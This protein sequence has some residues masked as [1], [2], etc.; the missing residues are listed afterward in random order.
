MAATVTSLTSPE[1]KA[2]LDQLAQLKQGGKLCFKGNEVS[3][4]S[5]SALLRTG[6]SWIGYAC[7]TGWSRD[8]NDLTSIVQRVSEF[9]NQ[10]LDGDQIL[11]MA[12]KVQS[13]ISGLDVLKIEYSLQADKAKVVENAIT[14]LSIVSSQMMRSIILI[15]QQMERLKMENEELKIQKEVTQSFLQQTEVPIRDL[16]LEDGFSEETEEK[17]TSD[18]EQELFDQISSI[19]EQVKQLRKDDEVLLAKWKENLSSTS[20]TSI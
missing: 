5:A 15:A 17:D 2:I 11:I 19:R 8:I 9:F 4:E 18:L 20:K 14:R 12:D 13:A 7:G 1:V 3:L 16:P 6:A 10:E